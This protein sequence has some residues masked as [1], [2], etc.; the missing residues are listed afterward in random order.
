MERDLLKR[1]LEAVNISPKSPWKYPKNAFDIIQIDDLVKLFETSLIFGDYYQNAVKNKFN[2]KGRISIVDAQDFDRKG[3]PSGSLGITD[4][5]KGQAFLIEIHK[6][7]VSTIEAALHEAIHLI[8]HPLRGADDKDMTFARRFG[9]SLMEAVT[10]YFTRIMMIEA[11][12]KNWKTTVYQKEIDN[13]LK[14]FFKVFTVLRIDIQKRMNI[15]CELVFKNN[16]NLLRACITQQLMVINNSLSER[17]STNWANKIDLL[18]S[19]KLVIKAVNLIEYLIQKDYNKAEK[20]YTDFR[21]AK[22]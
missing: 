13:Y 14:P 1:E 21:S 11:G 6:R 7:R 10:Q 9:Y 2:I 18:L 8:S 15:L 19:H 3:G 20:I 22:T 4:K 17:D 12:I 5:K 16:V